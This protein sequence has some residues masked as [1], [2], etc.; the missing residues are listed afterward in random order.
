M[1]SIYNKRGLLHDPM[2]VMYLSNTAVF[3]ARVRSTTRDYVFTGVCLFG[4][5]GGRVLPHLHPIIL[6]LVPCPFWGYLISIQYF[7]W[8][9]I[10]SGVP[11]VGVPQSQLGGTPVH[12]GVPSSQVWL[13]PSARTG[14]GYPPAR[15]E[16]PPPQTCYAWTGYAAGDKPLAVFSFHFLFIDDVTKT[17]KRHQF[18]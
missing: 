11:Q 6:P 10:P 3:T 17:Q 15:T 14:M 8:S 9:H 13:V 7:H 16:V 1:Q 12:D 2:Y 18:A 5:G 4:W